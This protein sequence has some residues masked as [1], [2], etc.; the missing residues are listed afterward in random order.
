MPKISTLKPFFWWNFSTIN[1][2]IQV[3]YRSAPAFKFWT[4][5]FNRIKNANFILLL[6]LFVGENTFDIASI[7]YHTIACWQEVTN[8]I[9]PVARFR[10]GGGCE[11]CEVWGVRGVGGVRGES[12]SK[13]L[14]AFPTQVFFFKK[15]KGPENFTQRQDFCGPPPEGAQ[16]S[17]I[18]F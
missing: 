3:Q 18:R 14:V 8:L 16:K 9:K 6:F 10:G 5:F 4:L 11:G 1:N 15:K 13:N 2:E 12:L 17:V 7:Q